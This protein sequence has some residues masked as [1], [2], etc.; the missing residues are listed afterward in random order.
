MTCVEQ[1]PKNVKI[2][3]IMEAVLGV[4]NY[5]NGGGMKGGALGFKISLLEKAADI[6]SYD[7]KVSL[8]HYIVKYMEEKDPS[9][10]E[11]IQE[12]SMLEQAAKVPLT[13]SPSIY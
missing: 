10:K 2:Q 11:W 12:L 8:L 7:P 3:K 1:I 4:G 13:T 9:V 5:C 6:K